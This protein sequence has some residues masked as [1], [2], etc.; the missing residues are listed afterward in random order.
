MGRGGQ[1]PDQ[2]TRPPKAAASP[3]MDVAVAILLSQGRV[4]IQ[5]R[6][7]RDS[8]MGCWEFPGGKL[9]PGESVRAGLRREVREELGLDLSECPVELYGRA[10]YCY[11]EQTVDI[12]FFLCRLPTPPSPEPR[13][14]GSNWP[15]PLPLSGSPRPTT[16]IV[17]KLGEMMKNR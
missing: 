3:R 17:R 2:V 5:S 8:L 6:R 9:K 14:G 16:S 1:R 11:P 15:M 7:T 12:R 13:A 10:S 4:W